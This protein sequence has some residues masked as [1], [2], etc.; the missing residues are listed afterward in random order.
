MSFVVL[1]VAF[2]ERKYRGGFEKAA[3]ETVWFMFFEWK[4]LCRIDKGAFQLEKV[5]VQGPTNGINKENS[6]FSIRWKD[7]I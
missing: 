3:N 5:F 4:F 7:A 1:P 2:L 6:S